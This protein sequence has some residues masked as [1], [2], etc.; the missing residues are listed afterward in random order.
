[1]LQRDEAILKHAV[2][3]QEYW[4]LT[5]ENMG[6]IAAGEARKLSFYER[7]KLLEPLNRIYTEAGGTFPPKDIAGWAELVRAE[8]DQK[9]K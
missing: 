9:T 7:L 8:F 5:T 2:A 1:M 4:R 6:L 3:T